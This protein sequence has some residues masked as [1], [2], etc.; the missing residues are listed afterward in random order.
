MFDDMNAVLVNLNRSNVI[1]RKS[2]VADRAMILSTNPA[3]NWHTRLG[4][5]GKAFF[6]N[7]YAHVFILRLSPVEKTAQRSLRASGA[8]RRPGIART[9]VG[10]VTSLPVA[11]VVTE[12]EVRD[13][14]HSPD[15]GAKG[16][17]D[18]QGWCLHFRVAPDS[19]WTWL[20]K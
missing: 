4:S 6:R 13:V 16:R 9:H 12:F 20:W 3:H 18:H 11:G 10:A 19:V 17:S 5:L 2:K 15:C 14:C 1:G 7:V 8:Q